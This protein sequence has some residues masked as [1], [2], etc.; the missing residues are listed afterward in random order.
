VRARASI[1]SIG[2]TNGTAAAAAASGS[3]TEAITTGNITMP[4][5]G[6]PAMP[7]PASTEASTTDAC[8]VRSSS[9]PHA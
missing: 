7:M 4:A 6:M 1:Q 8:C 2:M 9:K 3:P 5:S